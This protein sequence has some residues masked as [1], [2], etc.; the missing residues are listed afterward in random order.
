MDTRYK[1][2]KEGE[3][4]MNNPMTFL[5]L[6]L[7]HDPSRLLLLHQQGCD[8]NEVCKGSRALGLKDERK[9]CKVSVGNRKACAGWK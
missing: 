2:N 6:P 5:F 4:S 1:G 9:R 8:G 7:S 3:D